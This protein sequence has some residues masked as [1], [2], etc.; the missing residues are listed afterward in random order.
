MMAVRPGNARAYCITSA[1]LGS[2]SAACALHDLRAYAEPYPARP[3]WTSSSRRPGCPRRARF[4]DEAVSQSRVRKPGLR[5]L[6]RPLR[7]LAAPGLGRARL[8]R[9]TTCRFF[10]P[11]LEKLP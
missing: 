4:A 10:E 6:R 3:L 11:A 9:A 2:R 5:S 1:T 7:D 8:G